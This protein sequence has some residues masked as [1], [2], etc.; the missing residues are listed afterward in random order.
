MDATASKALR[1]I[2]ESVASGRYQVLAHFVQRMDRRGLFWVD[3]QAVIDS[4]GLIQANGMDEW[5]RPKWI[6]QGRTTGRLA[7]GIVC[8]LDRDQRGNL[9]VFIT[10]YWDGGNRR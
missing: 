10:A 9:I 2:Q 4:P 5:G 7:L 3:I 1:A 6:L 8:A